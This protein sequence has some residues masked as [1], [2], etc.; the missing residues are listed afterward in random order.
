MTATAYLL[1]FFWT[2][3][4]PEQEY[5]SLE[6]CTAYAQSFKKYHEEAQVDCMPAYLMNGG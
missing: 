1:F 2:T 4:I 6:I 5:A 3:Y